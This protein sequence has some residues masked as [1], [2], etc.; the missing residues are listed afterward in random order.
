MSKVPILIALLSLSL[1]SACAEAPGASQHL[2]TTTAGEIWGPHTVGQTFIAD[3]DGLNRIDVRLATY[4]R[5]N[6]HPVTFH[7]LEDGSSTEIHTVTFGADTVVDNAY[8]TFTFPPLFPSAGRRYRFFFDSPSSVTGDAITAWSVPHDAYRAGQSLLDGQPQ[9]GDLDFRTYMFYPPHQLIADLVFGVRDYLS[10]I[11]AIAVLLLL[12]GAALLA[13]LKPFQTQKLDQQVILAAVSGTAF[14]PLILMFS[15]T[16]GLYYQADLIWGILVVLAGT[17]FVALTRGGQPKA[18]LQT[19]RRPAPKGKVGLWAGLFLLLILTRVV[20]LRFLVL[21][22][23]GDGYVHATV[24]QRIVET[25][26]I[27][28]TFRPYS[29][30]DDFVYHFGFHSLVAALHFLSGISIPQAV[31]ILGQVMNILAVASVAYLTWRMTC[32]EWASATAFVVAGFFS[33]MPAYYLNWSRLTQL[34]GQ[35]LLPVA[36]ALTWELVLRRNTSEPPKYR[37]VTRAIFLSAILV[38]GLWLIHYRVVLLYLAFVIALALYLGLRWLAR[39]S[40]PREMLFSLLYLAAINGLA[41]LIAVLWLWHPFVYYL[42]RFRTRFAPA[43]LETPFWVAFLNIGDITW[44]VPLVIVAV[45]AGL[46]ALRFYPDK[47]VT[48]GLWLG[49]LFILSNPYRLGL[50]GA[51]LV[52]NFAVIIALYIPLAMLIG[53]GVGAASSALGYTAKVLEQNVGQIANLS[54]A[55]QACATPDD[56]GS[57]AAAYGNVIPRRWASLLVEL[58]MLGL[59]LWQTP[60]QSSV[61]EADHIYATTSDVQAMEWIRHNT[62]ENAIFAIGYR[63]EYGGTVPYAIDGG[64]W[65]PYLARRGTTIPLVYEYTTPDE[66]ARAITLAELTRDSDTL[67]QPG[68]LDRLRSA[69]VTHIYIGAMGNNLNS[70]ALARDP[71]FQLV[72]DQVGVRIFE[73][74]WDLSGRF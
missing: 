1:V 13:W 26:A 59:A 61:L 51:G 16:L 33:S 27:P 71:R 73:I 53:L 30:T 64:L 45:V 11:I 6:T 65:I 44:L 57:L 70:D 17:T 32:N 52:N 5:H 48:V 3:R 2:Y 74:I 35:V 56:L 60:A 39:R 47:V 19:F 46:W 29:P 21:P 18:L 42:T 67:L 54:Y 14:W 23:F 24:A 12:P 68:T 41:V 9:P 34:T 63:L 8:R 31:L 38:A 55:R 7:F 36:M 72:Y 62:H 10:I 22:P 50:P 58:I 43:N 20:P 25:G 37:A 66:V 40:P 15:S 28:Q 4:A 69:G 49:M